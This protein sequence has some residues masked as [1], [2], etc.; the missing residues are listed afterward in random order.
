MQPQIRLEE[1]DVQKATIRGFAIMLVLCAGAQAGE[2]EP[3]MAVRQLER[4]RNSRKAVYMNDFGE[5]G[6]YRAANAKLKPP[7]PGENRVVFFG[8]SITDVWSLPASFPGKPYVNRGVGGQ[9]TSQLLVRFRHDVIALRPKV[10][11]ILAGTNDIAG[12]T[13]PMTIEDT[14]ANF[15]SMVE[16]ARANG[17]KVVLSS[18]LPVHNYTPSS[19]LTFPLRPPAKIAA[20]N[21]WLKSYASANGCGYV[22]YFSAMVD[23]RGLLKRELAPDGLHPTKTGFALMAPLAQRAIDKAISGG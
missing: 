21:D 11:V 5:I 3:S 19:E 10:V 18:I 1:D 8:D 22:D 14:Q 4:W 23:G 6:R 9:T 20:L 12:N 17:I 7:A 13:G 16:L 15:A 2:G